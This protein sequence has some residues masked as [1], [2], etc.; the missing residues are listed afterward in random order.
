LSKR[1]NSSASFRRHLDLYISVA[2]FAVVVAVY[3]QVWSHDFVS[4]DDPV[5]V[6]ANPHVRG[7]LAWDGLRWALTS[8]HG[9]NWFPI[10]W[11][12]HMLDCQLFGLNAGWHHF[13]NVWIHALSTVCLFLLLSRGTGA[14]WRSA[15]VACIFALHPL[16]VESV[17]WIAERK[18][19]LSG[20]FWMLTL[21]AYFAY[22][23]KPG[24]MRYALV[25]VVF[26]LGLM[27]KPM[28][29]TLPVVLLLLDRWPLNRKF[30]ILEKLPFF[31]ASLAASIIT[32][33]VHQ[34]GGA[35]ASVQLVP[36]GPRVENALI[37]Y[38]AYVLKTFW[39]TH[40]AVFYPFSLRGLLV[41]AALAAILLIALTW[42]AIHWL[43][44]R[45]YLAVGWG[46]YLVTLL[47]VIGLIQ[48]GEQSRADRYTYIPMIGLSIALVWGI[49][50]ALQP[51]P[52]LRAALAVATC[53]ICVFLTSLQ[54][55]YWRDSISLYQHAIEVV[56]DSYE[57][58][59]NLA[60]VLEARG[61]TPGAI[62]QLQETVRIRPAYVPARAELGQ[63]L[64]AQGQIEDGIRELQ[65]AVRMRPEDADA[66]F[67]LGSVYAAAGRVADAADEFSQTIRLQPSNSDAHYNRAIALA[68]E[69]KLQ[70]AEDEFRETVRLRPDDP[71][72]HFNLGIAL[73]E[74]GQLD[75]A[76]AEFSEALRLKPDFPE[77]RQALESAMESKSPSAN[78]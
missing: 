30:L 60:A 50:D 71:E 75:K 22:V 74:L 10:T 51:W 64:A 67:R 16:H 65:T 33:V 4:Y 69:D 7:G 56:P 39:P 48:T 58:R 73:A 26:C 41:P 42:L 49:A 55:R 36:F 24:R 29:V 68:E 52:R 5:Y 54:I 44:T 34:K 13:T 63:L 78:R 27:S 47:P 28:L 12:S 59:F 66:H 20:L 15:V 19:V 25:L 9:A 72:A 46:W 37:S 18:D 1:A 3:G 17:A 8:G 11:I 35:V 43:P 6:T 62:A 77:A 76:S 14:R 40:L 57:A 38:V 70:E 31:A 23:T 61:D 21:F 53:A 32:L 2:L 45:P